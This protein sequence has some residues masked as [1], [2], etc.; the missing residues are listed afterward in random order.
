M[1]EQNPIS[2]HTKTAL[3][4]TAGVAALG[5]LVWWFSKPA[6]AAKAGGNNSRPTVAMVW[7]P[8]LDKSI[9][10]GQTYRFSL[11]DIAKVDLAT[12]TALVAPFQASTVKAYNQ[13]SIIVNGVQVLGPPPADW[14]KDDPNN[15]PNAYKVEGTAGASA[16]FA[17]AAIPLWRLSPVPVA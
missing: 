6:A 1:F 17:A 16:S 10:T 14:P 5:G 15:G 4:I 2:P 12:M 3:M 13:G 7:V 11:P 8:V 9:V